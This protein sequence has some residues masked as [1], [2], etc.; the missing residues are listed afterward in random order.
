M[1]L[2]KYKAKRN[3]AVTSEPKGKP[4]PKKV[5]GASR[6]V[7]QKH[8]ASRLHYDFRLEMDGVLKSWAVPK[9]L[10]WKQGE[11]HLAVEVEDHPIEYENFEGIIPKGNY[12]GGTVMVWDRGTYYVY[13]EDP[14]GALKKGRLHLVLDGQKAKGEWALIRI[15][16]DG[17]KNQWLLLKAT[18]SV[19]PISKKLD[20]QSVLTRRTMKQIADD[21]DA[22]WESD[23]DTPT[24]KSAVSNLKSRIQSALKKKESRE[25]VG[26]DGPSR[27]QKQTD[28]NRGESDADVEFD[29]ATGRRAL[30]A[31][32]PR[33]IEPIKPRLVDAPP[34]RGDWFY[35]LKFDGIRLIA[36]KDG[37]KVK[38]ISR[39]KNDLTTRFGELI[40]SL[41]GLPAKEFVIDGEVVAVDEKGRSSF[42]LLQAREME[43]RKSPIY[44]Y[45]FDLLQLNGKDLTS[46]PLHARKA[47][48]EK[49]C[50]D[51]ADPLRFSGSLGGDP[52]TLLR[53]VKRRGLEGIIGKLRDSVYEPGKRSGAWIKL[54]CV[55][56]Q[57]FVIGGYTPPQ[58]ARQYFG[59]ILVGY[60]EKKK[61]LFA[62]KV[63]TGFDT[64]MLAALYKRFKKEERDDCPFADLPSKQGGQWVQGITPGVMRKMHW[65]NPVLIAQIKFAE[66]T[67]DLKLRQPVF[68]GLREDKE[69]SEVVRET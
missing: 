63:G 26:R 62:G 44:F 58:G 33:F 42:Q 9:G 46:V 19:K 5:K 13:G 67:R 38:L 51:A 24:N 52:Q 57:E 64:K 61:L 30:P 69:P 3:F 23:R 15:R 29:G 49:L 56:E 18:K 28:R 40:D 55:N 4:L 50:A 37:R 12:G 10:P 2:E 47:L 54:K 14:L 43:N 11:K 35:E 34:T 60:Y 48:L 31:A 27:R 7:I 66:W 25:K 41:E 16:S 22:E 21:R 1:A 68:L 65:L 36:I 39:N 17:E 53:E 32:K 20:D 45:V 6:F 59:A 8:D